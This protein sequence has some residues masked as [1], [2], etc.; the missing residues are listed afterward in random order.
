MKVDIYLPEGITLQ[1]IDMYR[2]KYKLDYKGEVLK[3]GEMVFEIF[4][5][6]ERLK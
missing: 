2:M 1:E 4:D 5:F 6:K 3:R